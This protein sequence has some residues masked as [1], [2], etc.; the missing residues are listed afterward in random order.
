MEQ[1]RQGRNI[2]ERPQVPARSPCMT[3]PI[4]PGPAISF[5]FNRRQS[6]PIRKLLCT[7]RKRWRSR[8]MFPLTPRP[9]AF[10]RPAPDPPDCPFGG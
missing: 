3:R 2:Q 4:A 6:V 7:M 10:G 9:A 5:R 8:N 1:N